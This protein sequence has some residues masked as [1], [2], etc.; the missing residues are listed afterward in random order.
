MTTPTAD[1][2]LVRTELPAP[3]SQRHA[4]TSDTPAADTSAGRPMARF[5]R[6]QRRKGPMGST[7]ATTTAPER[8]NAFQQTVLD[9]YGPLALSTDDVAAFRGRIRFTSLGA[10]QLSETRIA[11]DLVVRRT[12]RL[13]RD[14]AQDYLKVCLPL[15]GKCLVAQDGREASLAPGDYVLYDNT[16]PYSAAFSRQALHVMIPR[17]L[18][19]LS[20]RQLAHIT[21]QRIGGQQGL[22]ALVSAFLRELGKHATEKHH[23]G[24]I[25][26]ADA[27]LDMLAASFAERLS[28]DT[29]IQIALDRNELLLLR[30]HAFIETRLS[31]PHL[32]VSSVAA[33]HH[34]SE[35]QLQK[36][37]EGEGCTV[38]R[39]IRDRRI[40]HCRRDLSDAQ[41]ADTPVG[42]IAARWGLVNAA[43]F[44][45]RFRAAHGMTPT[46]Y[47]SHTLNRRSSDPK[48]GTHL[49]ADSQ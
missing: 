13:I 44:S 10:V 23:V 41:Y 6:D 45:R 43:Y 3:Q 14:N 18:I 4:A 16:R 38:T 7:G 12:P 25:Y 1:S 17:D 49:V 39:W 29:T 46:E 27:V 9:A 21:A 47:R 48:S 11:N 2:V 28:N 5:E 33:A 20:H 32:D 26:L 35:R 31:E 19:R 15:A 36:L 42:S 34:I 24:N 8:F 40:E 30:I 37:F 22:G